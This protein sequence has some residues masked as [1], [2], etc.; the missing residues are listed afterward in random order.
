M[1]L[2]KASTVWRAVMVEDLPK[3]ELDGR[4]GRFSLWRTKF[5]NGCAPAAISSR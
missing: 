3:V 4:I 1:T 5:G 2:E